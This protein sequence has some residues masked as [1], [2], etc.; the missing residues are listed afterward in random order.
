MHSEKTDATIAPVR[1]TAIVRCTIQAAFRL[2][3]EEFATWWPLNTHSIGQDSAETCGIE[4][5]VGG[6]IYE[7]LRDGQELIWGK[8]LR[9][10]PPHALEFTWHP[11]REPDS[12]QTVEVTFT[13][14][15][16]GTRVDLTHSGWELLGERALETRQTYDSG[17]E[18][19]FVERYGARCAA[20]RALGQAKG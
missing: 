20:E 1:K 5:H 12:A 6:R 7:R 2:F 13:A 15:G 17:W 11:G 10:N 19:V 14:T 4:G 3:A 8:V 16:E 9:W 18:V